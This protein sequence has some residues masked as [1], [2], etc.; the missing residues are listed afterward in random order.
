MICE[1]KISCL[2]SDEWCRTRMRSFA[3]DVI[4]FFIHYLV[5]KVYNYVEL[6]IKLKLYIF[7]FC[8]FYKTSLVKFDIYSIEHHHRSYNWKS[9]NRCLSFNILQY[10]ALVS[11][12]TLSFSGYLSKCLINKFSNIG[13]DS[14]K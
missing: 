9:Y 1:I 11:S 14:V 12:S 4:C 13:L 6:E 3:T 10:G 5:V 7:N 2:V 8:N